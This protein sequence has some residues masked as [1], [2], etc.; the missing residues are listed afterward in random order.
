VKPLSS[1][2]GLTVRRAERWAAPKPAPASPETGLA[3]WPSVPA[4]AGA[5]P[6]PS[7]P[8]GDRATYSS[9]EGL[10]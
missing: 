4:Q 10:Q 6:R 1:A 8:L 2:E 7:F 5:E 3:L 9:A